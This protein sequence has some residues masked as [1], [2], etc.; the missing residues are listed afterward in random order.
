M[1]MERMRNMKM[2]IKLKM[3]ITMEMK[4]KTKMPELRTLQH[5]CL[6]RSQS[7]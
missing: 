2:E 7:P 4:M 5:S 3:R 6:R 1:K